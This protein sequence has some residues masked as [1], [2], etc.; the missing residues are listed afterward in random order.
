VLSAVLI[1]MAFFG[2]STGV[3][4]RQFSI[5]LVSAMALSV[6]VALTLTP[7]PVRQH[8]AACP[9]IGTAH[10][11]GALASFER[12]FARLS[13]RYQGPAYAG[14]C[15]T[16]TAACW[17][18]WRL[19]ALLALLYVKL[20]TAFLPEEDQGAL[21]ALIQLP[22]GAT[23]ERTVEVQR[24]LEQL[25]RADRDSVESG[26][27]GGRPEFLGNGQNAG[28]TFVRLR[29]WSERRAAGKAAS[30]VA[31]RAMARPARSAT[32]ASSLQGPPIIRGLGPP[33]AS[34]CSSRTP[35]ASAARS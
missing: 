6:I 31:K 17:C 28:M 23:L 32:P 26:P 21:F 9:I 16:R 34:T 15:R 20:P 33:A 12:G 13:L 30:M 19:L 27:V 8:P 25:I 24:Q 3:I 10:G 14:S 2:G 4:Y 11:S 7:A 5:T 22:A 18:T 1:P 35:A 29:D